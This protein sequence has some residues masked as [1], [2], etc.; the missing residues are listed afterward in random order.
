MEAVTEKEARDWLDRFFA[1]WRASDGDA[2]SKL[3]SVD[4]LYVV[5]PYEEPWP[6]GQRMTGRDQIAA[7]WQL[8]TT[9]HIRLLD[10]GYDLWAVNGDEAYARWWADL[11]LR[12]EG[13]WV[14]AEGVFKLTFPDRVNH[15]LCSHLYEWNPIE[16]ESARHYEPYPK[17]TG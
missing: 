16:P 6:D 10:G 5:T 12:G 15:L 8:V 14:E 1:A 13:C 2:A 11:E 9:E 7:F 17:D 4:A 3:F